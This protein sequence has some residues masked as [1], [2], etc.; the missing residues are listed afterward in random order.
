MHIHSELFKAQKKIS[1][2]FIEKTVGTFI[3]KTVANFVEKLSEILGKADTCFL[4]KLWPDV[5]VG[6]HIADILNHFSV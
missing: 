3:G 6:K 1:C 5:N 2:L 4:E